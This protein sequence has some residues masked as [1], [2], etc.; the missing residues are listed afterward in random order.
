MKL[1]IVIPAFNESA[2]LAGVIDGLKL[3]RSPQLT[4]EI[5]LVDD[6]STDDTAAIRR[7]HGAVVLRHIINRG[8]GAA[9]ATGLLSALRRGA[10]VI[11]TCDADGQHA[12]SDVARAV[13]ELLVSGADIAIGSRML[14]RSGM[15]CSRRRA[16]DL[17]NLFTRIIFGVRMSDSQSGLRVFTR[18]AA[19]RLR[20][21]ATNYEVSSEICGEIGRLGLKLQ[22]VPIQAIYTDYSLSKGQS[23][24]VGIR[25]LSRLILSR[26]MR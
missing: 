17:A 6:G 5:I 1:A 15:P 16:N 4:T 25:T 22:E 24:Q 14:D 3:A 8:L 9:L 23:F 18:R 12:P 13:Q 11:A 26:W 7:A 21:T 20:I 10:D 19:E 2:T